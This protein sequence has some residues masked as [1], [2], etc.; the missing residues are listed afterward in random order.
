MPAPTGYRVESWGT[1]EGSRFV[2]MLGDVTITRADAEAALQRKG[3]QSYG[4]VTELRDGKSAGDWLRAKA[5]REFGASIA[6][7]WFN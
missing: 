3:G 1:W 4:V 6:R 5:R 2:R 7:R